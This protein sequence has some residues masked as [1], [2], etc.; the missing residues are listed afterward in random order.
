[1]K[2]VPH[3]EHV[4]VRQRIGEKVAGCKSEAVGDP[5]SGCIGIE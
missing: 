3:D 1:M 2:D 4:G 5:G